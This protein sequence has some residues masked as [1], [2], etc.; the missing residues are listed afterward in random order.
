MLK[1]TI[2]EV[3]TCG[4][5]IHQEQLKETI[6][7]EAAVD[8]VTLADPDDHTRVSAILLVCPK[9]SKALDEG[10]ELMFLADNGVD[11]I[12]VQF[13]IDNKEDS[14]VTK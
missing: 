10:H 13:S 8:Q 14:D 4:V 5:V 3:P 12:A 11:H 2:T 6:C 1:L 9:H 7:P